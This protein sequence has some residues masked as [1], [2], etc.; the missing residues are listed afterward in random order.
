MLSRSARLLGV[1]HRLLPLLHDVLRPA[2]GA[3]WVER[4]HLADHKPVEKHPHRGE[5]L[6]HRRR[7]V[8]FAELLDVGADHHRL[9]LL[10]VLA[11]SVLAPG[12]EARRRPVVRSAGVG[13][14]DVCGEELEEPTGGVIAGVRDRCRR[15][16]EGTCGASTEVDD[17]LWH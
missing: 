3:R 16:V 6:L 13:I 2:H 11:P 15:G 14:P 1:E 5:V 9:D 17:V 12:E 8:S 10:Q 4:E 7:L